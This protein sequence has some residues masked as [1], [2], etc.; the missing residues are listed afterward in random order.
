MKYIRALIN[1][2]VTLGI[3]LAGLLFIPR[4]LAFFAPFV[5]GWMIALLAGAPVK[6]FEEK[7]RIQPR[8]GS[9]FF[10]M[11]VIGII[12]L[13]LYLLG[14]KLVGDIREVLGLLPGHLE[15]LRYEILESLDKLRNLSDK[16]PESIQPDI[17]GLA[18][19]ISEYLKTW[20]RRLG[21]PTVVALG[22]IA[23][24]LPTLTMGVLMCLFSAYLFV[25][26]KEKI[27]TWFSEHCPAR[28]KERYTLFRRCLM[29][30]LGGYIRAQLKIELWI[31]LVT[32]A[33]LL[34]LRV[35]YA[36]LIALG[37]AVLDFLPFFGTG[38]VMLPW[39]LICIFAGNY[40]LAIGLF[41]LWG[42]GQIL[43]QLIQ[44]KIVGEMM[45]LSP[46]ATLFLLYV[47]YRLWGVIGMLLAVPVGL[48]L[49]TFYQAGVFDELC[50][51]VKILWEGLKKLQKN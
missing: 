28:I 39:A 20:I 51:S 10:I 49:R 8:A 3:A 7:M 26:E 30:A 4:V 36:F 23:R 14:R 43:R 29:D 40:F 37:I 18:G 24:Y 34:F 46:L 35:E 38:T 42:F 50:T 5:L 22:S 32:A 21:S 41:V 47:G 44:P 19:D 17:P 11:A 1:V 25:V 45:G 31:Y 6:Y 2:L 9:A 27:Q 16:L 15:E 48:V 33:G 12:V 13:I